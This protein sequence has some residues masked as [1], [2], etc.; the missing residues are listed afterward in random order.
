LADALKQLER[1]NL[2]THKVFPTAPIRVEYAIT[3]LGLSLRTSFEVS[4][5]WAMEHAD[6]SDEKTTSVWYP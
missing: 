2:V 3:E 4:C 5:K 1:K 6:E